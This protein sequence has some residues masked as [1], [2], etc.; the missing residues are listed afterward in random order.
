VTNPVRTAA[1]ALAKLGFKVFPVNAEYN[2][3][4]WI[5]RPG[6]KNGF[7][8]ASTD[9]NGVYQMF[10]FSGFQ[11]QQFRSDPWIGM[12][13]NDMTILDADGADGIETLNG[14][15]PI[16]PPASLVV[17]TVSG[18][19]HYYIP[20]TLGEGESRDTRALPGLDILTGNE[21]GFVCVP[22]SY[23]Y[24]ILEGSFEKLAEEIHGLGSET[25]ISPGPG[26][27]SL[28]G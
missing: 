25:E 22:P 27:D 19:I 16:I 17:Q 26:P 9:I 11:G 12:V 5:K 1:V 15:L 2:G 7:K 24:R 20:G 28:S 10:S 23:G 6:T 3:K 18:G 8:D 14:I 4:K 13:H 21:K